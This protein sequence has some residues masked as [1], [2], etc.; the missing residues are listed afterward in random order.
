ME[1][2]PFKAGTLSYTKG[3]LAIL[4]F[5]LL[6]GDFCYVLMEAVVPSII[7]LKFKDLGSDDTL[8]GVFMVSVPALIAAVCNPIISV[9]SD[10]HRGRFGRRIPFILFSMPFL[11]AC[12]IGLGF[13]DKL[14]AKFQT[15]GIG[16]QVW[17]WLHH[18]FPNHFSQF[19]SSAAILIMLCLFLTLFSFFNTFVNSVF[20]Y[21]FNDVVPEH[22]LARF[23]SWFRMVSLGS[24]SIYNLF[25]FKHAETHYTE[26]FVG[27][28][29]LYFFGFTLMCWRVREGGYPPPPEYIGGKTGIIAAVKTYAKECLCVKHYWFLF[30]AYMVHSFG[31]AAGQFGIYLQRSLGFSLEQIG[32]LGFAYTCSLAI[33]IPVSGWLADR[34]HPIRVVLG[35]LFLQL[36][37]A[38][39]S[40]LWVFWQPDV[41][42]TFWVVLAMNVLLGAPV[43]CLIS[44]IDPPLL[45]RIFPRSRYGQ[46]CSANAMLRSI[47]LIIAG[48]AVGI[49]LDVLKSYFPPR[50]AYCCLSLWNWVAIIL[51]FVAVFGLYRSWKRHGGDG[52]YIPPLP[53]GEKQEEMV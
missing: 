26:I 32:Q 30:A 39:F 34:F 23:I 19:S 2:Q 25:V 44:M 31:I 37:L 22:L 43:G 38:P 24:G 27:A 4:F 6:W 3:T 40:M 29:I 36:F 9:K 46:F 14:G 50:T 12:L 35:G 41:Q 53:K 18:W 8:V 51:T 13:I 21:L 20:W 16:D 45:M 42:V 15:L 28:G 5:W 48:T 33:A 11:V 1:E 49:Y 17:A 47:A 52:S 7:P 10:R